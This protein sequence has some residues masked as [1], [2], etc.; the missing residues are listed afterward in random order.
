MLLG[1]PGAGKTTVAR[2]VARELATRAI[3]IDQEI[4]RASGASISE[5]FAS[6]GEA[7][8]RALE[9]QAMAAAVAAEPAVI[10][11]GGGWAAQPGQLAAVEPLALT[12]YLYVPVELAAARLGAAVDRP[13]LA[14]DPV[15]RLEALLAERQ[16]WY[17]RAAIEID[18]APAPELVAAAVVTAARQYGGWLP[19]TGRGGY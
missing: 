12:I 19:P 16:P 2:R 13:L 9:R 8:F 14:A 3:D 10:S 7:A 5:L 11:P 18:A 4:E 6:R 17:R 1:L 15:P